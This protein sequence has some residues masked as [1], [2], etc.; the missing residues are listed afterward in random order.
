MTGLQNQQIKGTT[1]KQP[2]DALG[3]LI[4]FAK[5]RKG[6]AFSPEEVTLSA[7]EKGIAFDDL[8]AWGSVFTQAAME[9]HIRRSTELFS[10][11]TS[12]GSV[13]PGWIGN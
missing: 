12:N 1:M 7:A 3:Y 8:R 6:R 13:R 11:A 9:G 4:R 5:R 2:L 10:R